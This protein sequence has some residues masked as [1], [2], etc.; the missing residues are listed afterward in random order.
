MEVW[1]T[2]FPHQSASQERWTWGI[3]IVG[4]TGLCL[5]GIWIQQSPVCFSYSYE[6]YIQLKFVCLFYMVHSKEISEK[7]SLVLSHRYPRAQM[8]KK[9]HYLLYLLY[10]SNGSQTVQHILK[11]FLSNFKSDNI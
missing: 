5:K 10:Q 11:I 6:K 3:S 1:R 2:I 9:I 4:E 8:K 7:L